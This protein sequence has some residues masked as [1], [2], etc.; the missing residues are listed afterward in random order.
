MTR[1]VGMSRMGR[2]RRSKGRKELLRD[3]IASRENL[4]FKD[5]SVKQDSWLKSNRRML[6]FVLVMSVCMVGFNILF[7]LWIV[8]SEFFQN[9]LNVNARASVVILHLLGDD[10]IA[11]GTSITSSRFSVSIERGCEA[12][13]VSMFFII[14]V[15]AWPLPV[16]WRQRSLG[17]IVGTLLLM[18]LNLVRIVSLYYTGVYFPNAF[19]VMHLDVWQPAFILLA[20]FFWVGWVWWVSRTTL[21]KSHVI[22]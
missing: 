16:S 11:K 4:A 21:V 8:P 13:Q 18:T 2:Y 3:S 9:Y 15:C 17:L 14:A 20:I 12:I 5:R 1:C 22:T 19:E 10:A 6:R 7:F